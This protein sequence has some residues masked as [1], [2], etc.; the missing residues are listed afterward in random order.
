[1][2]VLLLLLALAQSPVDLYK[3]GIADMD[4]SRWPEA[5]AKFEQIL[6]KDA[7]DLPAQFNLAICYA[8]LEKLP[9]AEHLYR[10]VLERDPEIY[11]ARF[12]LAIILFETGQEAAADE[13]FQR[14]SAMQPRDAGPLVYRARIHK[15]R[16]ELKEAVALYEAI[17]NI[18]SVAGAAIR[19]ELGNTYR[20]TKQFDKAIETLQ[21]IPSSENLE[22][23]LV[24]FD[25][26]DYAKAGAIFEVLSAAAPDDVDYLYMLGKCQMETKQ[27]GRAVGSL[28][29]VIKLKPD[30]IDAYSTLGATYYAQENWA[31]AATTLERFLQLKPRQAY[32]HF[33]LATC[34][35]K[36]GKWAPAVVNYNKFLEYDDGS[37]DPRSFQARQRAKTLERRLKK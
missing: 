1:M 16:G 30:Y 20:L 21:P 22:L 32:G 37:N 8:K 23:A 14:A 34:Y 4:A 24:Y 6:A 3:A 2:G 27:Y 33:L 7:T 31:N 18:D 9:Q 11:E 17:L 10:K 29:R 36:L 15:K 26:K 13:Q 25:M 35:D 12:N 28:Q 5:A 19:R